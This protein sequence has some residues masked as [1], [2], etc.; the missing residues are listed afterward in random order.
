MESFNNPYVHM[1]KEY[2]KK[3]IKQY[4]RN[5]KK[6]ASGRAKNLDFNANRALL[7]TFSEALNIQESNKFFND[8]LKEESPES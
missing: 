3:R 7:L 1:P 4:D 5:L 6:I 8:L 2:I